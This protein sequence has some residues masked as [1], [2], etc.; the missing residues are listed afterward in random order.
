MNYLEIVGF[1]GAFLTGVVIGL[2]GGGG[3]ILAV[4]IFV[5]LFKLNPVIATSYSMFV[6]GFSS[7]IG[8]LLNIK[9]KLIAYKTA[10]IFTFPAL[11]S[12]Y[13]TRRFLIPNIP[14]ILY[15]FENFEITK[16]MVL[17]LFFSFV[18]ILS[19]ILMM[20]KSKPDD[21]TKL[22]AKLNY[23]LLISNGVGVGVLT[24][25][26]GAGGGFIIVPALV[27]FARITIKQAVATSLIIITFNSLIGF[28]S[29]L[30]LLKMEWDFLILFTAISVTGIFVGTYISS[31]VQE[32]TLKTNFARFMIVMAAVIIFKEL[33]T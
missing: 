6:V 17:M 29:D 5:Y 12:V 20:R 21:I 18:I 28:S 16:K 33:M 15:S 13:M 30:F 32:S 24:G 10:V 1:F 27:V 3:S 14:D 31:Y 23:G 26:V 4:P 11:M 25:L 9:K 2:F 22:T 19:S 7:A 8:T